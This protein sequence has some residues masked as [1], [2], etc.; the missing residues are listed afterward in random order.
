MH[1]QNSHTPSFNTCY[2][3]SASGE[4][5]KI[6][7]QNVATHELGHWLTLL[8]LCGGGD[9]DKTMYGYTYAGETKKRTLD[10]DDIAGINYIYP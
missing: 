5:G 1:S 9:S 6:D 8:D 10:S 7:V 4:A 2:S 3:W